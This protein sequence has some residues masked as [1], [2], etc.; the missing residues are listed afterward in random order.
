VTTNVTILAFS[1]PAPPGDQSGLLRYVTNA[2]Q[3]ADAE[4]DFGRFDNDGPDGFPDSGD[5][6]GVVD[7]GI[8]LMNSELNRYCNGGTG[9]GPHPFALSSITPKIPTA[10][11]GANG[12]PIHVGGA[13]LMSAT[14]CSPAFASGH[15][16]A[17]E[18]GHLFL[19][20]PDL[21]HAIGGPGEVWATRRWVSGCWEL[22][23]AG[24]W[25]CGT[26]PPTFDHRINTLGAWPRARLAWANPVLVVPTRDMTYEL[27][28]M[29]RGG[30]VL[31]VPISADEYLLIEYRER[32]SFTDQKLPADG[33]LITHVVENIPQFPPTLTSPY[34]VSLIEAD[35]DSTLFR[36]ELQGGS[37]GES[38]DAFGI[39]GSR[40]TPMLHSR[41]RAADGTPFPFE[42]TGV[43][44]NA[45]AHRASLRIAPLP[46]AATR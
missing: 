29:G 3:L 19:G 43:T 46:A 15:I 11:M 22:M 21:Y 25:G 44:I 16:M 10:D 9:S 30:T 42:I 34:R 2:I 5:D 33:V 40:L 41:A 35:D 39:G 13:T 45:A 7:G 26:G 36:T 27:H 32:T 6:D 18:L 23:A 1:T 8:V 12:F 31:R 24:S 28:P 4:I 17:H 37:R 20:L 38:E 14:G